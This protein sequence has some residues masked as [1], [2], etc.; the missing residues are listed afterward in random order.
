MLVKKFRPNVTTGCRVRS[1]EAYETS[2]GVDERLCSE[3][4]ARLDSQAGDK[5]VLSEVSTREIQWGS[6]GDKRSKLESPGS[7]LQSLYTCAGPWERSTM[8]TTVVGTER[9]NIG[10]G[11]NS[12]RKQQG[13]N[14]ETGAI[15]LGDNVEGLQCYGGQRGRHWK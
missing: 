3:S 12:N 6:P 15:V 4:G 14:G 10:V 7:R 2:K 1:R 5:S 13:N 9:E 11:N 8:V